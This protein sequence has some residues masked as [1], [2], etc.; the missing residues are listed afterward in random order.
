M[1]R[2]DELRSLFA[3]MFYRGILINIDIKIIDSVRTELV[4]NGRFIGIN[5]TVKSNKAIG[6]C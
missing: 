6:L 2:R 3:F 1:I 4:G 5:E